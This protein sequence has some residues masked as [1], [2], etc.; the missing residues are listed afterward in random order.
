[1]VTPHFKFT[2][3]PLHNAP[4]TELAPVPEPILIE[5]YGAHTVPDQRDK[6]VSDGPFTTLKASPFE[7]VDP[8]P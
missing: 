7:F 3:L 5:P 8:V 6:F 4:V 2:F 1:M